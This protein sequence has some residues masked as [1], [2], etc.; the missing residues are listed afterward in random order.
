LKFYKTYYQAVVVGLLTSRTIVASI[1]SIIILS[2][3]VLAT[4]ADSP[5]LIEPNGEFDLTP[6]STGS[7]TTTENAEEIQDLCVTDTGIAC[8]VSITYAWYTIRGQTS[9]SIIAWSRDGNALWSKTYGTWTLRPFSVETDNE[10]IYVT[11]GGGGGLLLAKYTIDGNQLWNI[12]WDS[13]GAWD[14]T[15]LDVILADNG[16]IIVTGVFGNYPPRNQPMS[17]VVFQPG[18]VVAFDSEGR[19]L[20]HYES[21]YCP[22]AAYCEGYIYTYCNSSIQKLTLN[23]TKLSITQHE[24]G[25][26]YFYSKIG[27]LYAL[28]GSEFI[29]PNEWYSAI[30][31]KELSITRWNTSLVDIAGVAE[32]QRIWTT[33]ITVCNQL[34]QIYNISCASVTSFPDGSLL[35]LLEASTSD[36]D[37][38]W[39][40]LLIT[41][42]GNFRWLKHVMDDYDSARIVITDSGLL[43]LIAGNWE[44]KLQSMAVF[45][46][47]ELI[48][49]KTEG[50]HISEVDQSLNLQ[51]ISITA[52]GVILFDC[53]FIGFLAKKRKKQL[54]L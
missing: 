44:S 45:N 49:N 19:Y 9:S 41:S 2:L 20:W 34:N 29:W 10:F 30:Y 51:L 7:T 52:I 11:G 4:D 35:L 6:I 16:Y 23:G 48:P 37:R 31:A 18:F 39:Y 1:L 50:I 32:Q 24:N 22:H 25:V 5:I 28:S 8:S 38:S 13:G 40:I 54:I 12:T 36:I 33:N 17:V 3:L 43:F 15:G 26:W 27:I 21:A 42:D 47:T 46:I 14:E 53:L